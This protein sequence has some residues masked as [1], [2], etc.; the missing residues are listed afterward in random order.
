MVESTPAVAIVD[1]DP[2]VLKAL[3]RLL[4]ADGIPV[5]SFPSAERLFR[6]IPEQGEIGC[7]L[8]DI[9]M[10][11]IDGFALAEKLG[12]LAPII[13]MTAYDTPPNR[14]R[15]RRLGAVAL[16]TKP[17]TEEKLLCAIRK[18][19]RMSAEDDKTLVP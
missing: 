14:D 4:R 6:D 2:S 8:V 18:G 11:G 3:G 5:H 17:V 19:T 1:D 15:A 13:F 10:P 9:R 12:G 7:F 16:L